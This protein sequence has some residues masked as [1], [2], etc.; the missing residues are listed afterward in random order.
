MLAAA[1]AILCGKAQ[2]QN[3]TYTTNSDG[4]L[5][6]TGYNGSDTVITIPSTILVNGVNLTV[7]SIGMGAFVNKGLNSVTIPD[8]VTDIGGDAFFNCNSLTSVTIPDSV[9]SI[10]SAAFEYCS[11]LTNVTIG[12]SV[13][14]IGNNAFIEC[15]S[16]TS[17][18]IPDSVTSIGSAAFEYCSGLTNVTIGSSVTTIGNDTFNE[19]SSL[20]SITIPDSVTGLGMQAFEGCSN[21]TNITIGNSVTSIGAQTFEECSSLTN[22]NIGN[23]VTSIGKEAFF[24]CSSLNSVTLGNNVISFGDEA[25]AGCISLTSIAIPKSV[26]SIGALA[27]FNCTSLT[28]INVDPSNPDYSSV[29]GIL[30]DNNQTSLIQYPADKVGTFYAIPNSVTSIEFAAFENCQLSNVTIPNSVSSIGENA[31]AATNLT[32]ITIPNSVA[33]IGNATFI[34]CYNLTTVTI[35]S[36]VTIIGDYAFNNTGLTNVTIPDSVTQIGNQTFYA[37]PNL[38][39]ITIGNN[40]TF[41]GSSAFGYSSDLINVYFTGNA[42]SADSSVFQTDSNATVYY[43]P[44]TSGW[45]STYD[46]VPSVMMEQPAISTPPTNE[47]L[48]AGANATFAV[49]AS[50]IPAPSYQWQVSTDGGN[51][52][53]NVS[54]NIYAGATTA[55]L[56]ITNA[57]TAQL[58]YQY[59]AVLTNF[60]GTT[61]TAPVPLVVGTSNAQ[62]TWLQNN[63]TSAQ[64]GQPFI[65]GDAAD[66]AGDGIPNLLKYAFNLNPWVEGHPFLPQPVFAAGNLTLTFPAPQTDINYTVEASPDLINWSTA[67]VTQTSDAG[68]GTVT[69]SY[70][71]TGSGPVFLQIMVAPMP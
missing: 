35:S 51:T 20:T 46:G 69:G 55:N 32:S 63:F 52:W 28:A 67:G 2:A 9:T 60:A 70:G 53:N 37:C 25:F 8:T 54:G 14:S 36:N 6:I 7:T 13:T 42:P 3:F 56:T 31:F 23:S 10:G 61:T 71:L 34:D 45:G 44:G 48:V 12:S 19:C 58:G 30:F 21:L 4:S 16:L 59:Q 11:G 38:T 47:T 68:N 33:S 29:A 18:T 57:T 5:N 1:C 24:N 50:G 15:S 64:L 41:I 66:P 22:I 17:V 43:L 65:V 27:F 49:A 62:L 26:T 40:V 39:S